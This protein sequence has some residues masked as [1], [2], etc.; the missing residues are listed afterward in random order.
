VEIAALVERPNVDAGRPLRRRRRLVEVARHQQE[1]AHGSETGALEQL[2]GRL[3]LRPARGVQGRSRAERR[4]LHGS[5]CPALEQR[6][7]DPAP[8][9]LG[10]DAHVADHLSMRVL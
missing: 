10:V 5:R 7:R 6:G 1:V 9:R 3:V 2:R 8:R 4:E